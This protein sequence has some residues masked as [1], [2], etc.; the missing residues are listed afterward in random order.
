MSRISAPFSSPAFIKFHSKDSHIIV[1]TKYFDN[2]T[3][4]CSVQ[5]SFQCTV[6]IPVYSLHSSVQSSFRVNVAL[7]CY[8]HLCSQRCIGGFRAGN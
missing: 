5:S 8:L 4:F 6:F 3:C 7:A 2:I 1:V